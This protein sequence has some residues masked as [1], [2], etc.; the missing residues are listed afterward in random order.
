[1]LNGA[2]SVHNCKGYGPEAV[3]TYFDRFSR[4]FPGR[5]EEIH[6]KR[7]GTARFRVEISSE[8]DAENGS[9]CPG[10]IFPS[11]GLSAGPPPQNTPTA[12]LLSSSCF[13]FIL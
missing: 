3:L 5:T 2:F 11:D 12:P 1:V 6:E 9:I 7:I 10:L 4:H 13:P 8:C